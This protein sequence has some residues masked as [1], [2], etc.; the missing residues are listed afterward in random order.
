MTAAPPPGEMGRAA[1]NAKA[2][3]SLLRRATTARDDPVPPCVTRPHLFDPP[4]PGVHVRH[5]LPR[6][7]EAERLCLACPLLASCEVIADGF[8][9]LAAGRLYG[10]ARVKDGTP[11]SSVVPAKRKRRAA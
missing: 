2:A 7:L 5:V 8:H 1:M 11:P 3:A 10:I 9:G 6:F 4:A